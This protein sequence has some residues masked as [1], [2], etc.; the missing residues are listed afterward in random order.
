MVSSG[1]YL[2]AC[3]IG[4]NV[5][6]KA[7]IRVLS[8]GLSSVIVIARIFVERYTAVVGDKVLFV[9]VV[10]RIFLLVLAGGFGRTRGSVHIP[11]G[12]TVPT[13]RQ[14]IGPACCS[15]SLKPLQKVSAQIK[16]LETE[17]RWAEDRWDGGMGSLSR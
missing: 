17:E 5:T 13:A 11:L 7:R 16:S 9:S 3:I 1:E 8:I 10:L 14:S 4:R 15:R 6:L 12:A 2:S